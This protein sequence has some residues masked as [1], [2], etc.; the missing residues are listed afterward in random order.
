MCGQ[1]GFM[2]LVFQ[3]TNTAG[4]CETDCIQNPQSW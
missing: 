1:S 3:E 4:Q 2:N